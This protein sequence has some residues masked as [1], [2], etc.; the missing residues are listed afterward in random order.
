[1]DIGCGAGGPL[2]MTYKYRLF[3]GKAGRYG[4]GTSRY[5]TSPPPGRS[6]AGHGGGA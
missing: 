1:M 3:E 6:L 4:S 2:P 5:F